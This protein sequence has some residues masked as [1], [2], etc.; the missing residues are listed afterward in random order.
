MSGMSSQVFNLVVMLGSIQVA[1][2]IPFEDPYVL[3]TVRG[4]YVF[5]NVV[6]ALIY[7]YIMAQINKKKDMTTLKYVEPP[8]VGSSEEGKLVTTTIH[9]YDMQQIRS[10]FRGQLMGVAMVAFMHGYMKYTNPL[11]VQSILP[12]KNAIDSN[13]AKIYIFGAPAIGDLK[14][15]FKA[16]GGLMSAMQQGGVQSDKKAVEAAERAGRGGAKEE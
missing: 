6:I 9:D 3:N 14:R 8:P 1:K 11:I 2:Y 7:V 16:S 13:L 12:V 10:S 5:T 4:V 15:P